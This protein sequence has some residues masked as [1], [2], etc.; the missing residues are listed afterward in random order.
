MNR[1][2]RIS[3]GALTLLFYVFIVFFVT[4]YESEATCISPQFLT[5]E[6][7]NYSPNANIDTIVKKLGGL[8]KNHLDLDEII[9]T[10]AAPIYHVDSWKTDQLIVTN[11]KNNLLFDDD[12]TYGY[13]VIFT[14]NYADGDTAVL[15]WSS[16]RYGFVA[17]P[18]VVPLG[19]G[20]S[21]TLML[22]P[23]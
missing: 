16:W 14:V 1:Y 11:N 22:I 13:D 12:P 23:Q 4:K 21:G 7:Q 3:L 5:F 2:I 6:P 9:T 18:L 15:Q 19:N 8:P 17:C 20:P 10:Q